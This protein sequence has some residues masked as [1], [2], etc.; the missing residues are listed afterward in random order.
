MIWEYLIPG[1]RVVFMKHKYFVSKEWWKRQDRKISFGEAREMNRCYFGLASSC[2]APILVAICHE[3]SA[4]AG[5]YYS[6]AFGT[7]DMPPITWFD[8]Q[9]DTLY[10]DCDEVFARRWHDTRPYS[11][12]E[13]ELGKVDCSRVQNLAISSLPWLYGRPVV[14][15]I[16]YMFGSMLRNLSHEAFVAD[17]LSIFV[18]L[19][20]LTIVVG[21]CHFPSVKSVRLV[22]PFGISINPEPSQETHKF[23]KD[24]NAYFQLCFRQ[25][26]LHDPAKLARFKS[27]LIRDGLST[28]NSDPVVEI[29]AAVS[30]TAMEE[31][32]CKIV[33]GAI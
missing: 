25:V 14:P 15:L 2:P 33:R 10:M 16:G 1:P 19:K 22:E 20:K 26:K 32:L 8:F 12:I 30:E 6:K 24:M 23:K 18:D 4:I 17:M 7:S 13:E 3:S 31:G 11:E 5:R 21:Q 29:K 9:R 28:W 27:E